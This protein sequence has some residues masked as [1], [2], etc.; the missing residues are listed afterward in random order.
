M[1]F[2]DNKIVKRYLSTNKVVVIDTGALG[3]IQGR[4]RE[5]FPNISFIGFEPQDE[6]GKTI[7]DA[8]VIYNVA[9]SDKKGDGILYITNKVDGSS[10]LKPDESS[11]DRFSTSDRY[12]VINNKKI[13]I[14]TLDNQIIKNKISY[15]DFLKI[16][17]QGT[18]LGVLRGAE[19]LL[20]NSILGLE[21]ECN[22]A[23]RYEGQSYFSDVDHFLRGNGFELVDL[24]RRFMSRKE[25]LGTYQFKGQIT[26]GNTFYIRSISSFSEIISSLEKEDKISVLIRLLSV[27]LV[28]GYI[29][30]A[31]SF[32][33]K[34][35]DLF[36]AEDF[37]HLNNFF[38]L[39]KRKH[40]LSGK[41]ILPRIRKILSKLVNYMESVDKRKQVGDPDLGT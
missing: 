12:K 3:G 29:D 5:A 20:K 34:F 35:R 16:D 6:E 21:V 17:T 7:V 38:I 2:F 13:Y 31:N 41:P 4:W 14:D 18:E 25:G 22:F 30:I 24:S 23:S 9:I 28:Y 11:L 10:L 27:L 1:N 8:G 37:D 26:H 32:L 40:I 33:F 19:K 36:T 15:V 39:Q